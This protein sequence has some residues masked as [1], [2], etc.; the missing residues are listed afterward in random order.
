MRGP[1]DLMGTAQSGLPP[2]RLA[3]LVG[4]EELLYRARDIARAILDQDPLLQRPQHER[5]KC[6]AIQN[7]ENGTSLVN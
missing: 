3:S 2:L 5:L 6:F 1:G 7:D 4:D